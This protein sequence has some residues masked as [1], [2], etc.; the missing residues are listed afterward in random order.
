MVLPKRGKLLHRPR[1][2]ITWKKME[3][4]EK[5]GLPEIN[6]ANPGNEYRKGKTSFVQGRAHGL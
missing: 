1:K 3:L 5:V 2:S 6:L 4:G